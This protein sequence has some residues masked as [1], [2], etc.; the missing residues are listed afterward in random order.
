MI[1]SYLVEVV[2]GSGEGDAAREDGGEDGQPD[3]CRV[4]LEN[5]KVGEWVKRL[6]CP[7]RTH[8]FHLID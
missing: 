3:T 2:W 6:V 5:Y 7:T 1:A 8:C 4:C